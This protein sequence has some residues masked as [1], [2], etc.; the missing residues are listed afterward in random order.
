MDKALQFSVQGLSD[1]LADIGEG[2]E[3]TPAEE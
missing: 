2:M 3:E 1:A